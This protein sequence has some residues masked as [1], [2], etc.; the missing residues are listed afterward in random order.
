MMD[1]LA[2]AATL[3]LCAGIAQADIYTNLAG[4]VLSGQLVSVT[5]GLVSIRTEHGMVQ[6]VSLKDFPSAE[7]ERL[8]LAAGQTLPLPADLQ[9][10]FEHLR[11]MAIRA[12][13]QEQAGLHPAET[14][15]QRH[16]ELCATW[17]QILDT[18]L[19]ESRI[20]AALHAQWLNA[21]AAAPEKESLH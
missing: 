7:R 10:L 18:A 4:E 19:A 6:S 13:R 16:H 14:T 17:R 1:R 8:L 3:W 15:A 11:D 20:S 2:I 21:L 5:N 9:S 12:E